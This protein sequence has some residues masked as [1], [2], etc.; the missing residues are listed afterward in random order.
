MDTD[1]KLNVYK[2]FRKRLGRLVNVLCTYNFGY[3]FSITKQKYFQSHLLKQQNDVLIIRK[4][5]IK[6]AR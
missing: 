2:T 6:N 4:A 1:R 3:V 5:N